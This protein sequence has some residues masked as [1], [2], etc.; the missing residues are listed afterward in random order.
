MKQVILLS[1]FL[2][3]TLLCTIFHAL[4]LSLS[5]KKVILIMYDT[6]FSILENTRTV[7]R[8]LTRKTDSGSGSISSAVDVLIPEVIQ[9]Y[10][11]VSLLFISYQFLK[12]K[13]LS[14]DKLLFY[15]SVN[16]QGSDFRI[17]G[18]DSLK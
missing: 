4:S 11:S 5:H 6:N 17:Y 12:I 15:V 16:G 9:V 1:Q 3:H 7:S 18:R 2:T 13:L 10:L 8:N 14:S